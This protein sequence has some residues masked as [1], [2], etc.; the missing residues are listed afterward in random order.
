LV[1]SRPTRRDAWYVHPAGAI[2]VCSLTV[3]VRIERQAAK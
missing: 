1:E 2:D 3:P